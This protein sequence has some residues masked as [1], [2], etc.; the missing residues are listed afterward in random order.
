MSE[1]N[2]LYCFDNKFWKMALVSIYS[3]LKSKADGT[4]YNIYC[5][6]PSGTRWAARRRISKIIRKYK[7]NIIFRKIKAKENPYGTY[8]Y[9]RWSPVIFYR[10]FAHKIFPGAE[11]MLY[12]DSDVFVLQDL[13]S[14]FNTDLQKYPIAGVL[15]MAPVE[16]LQNS[17]GKHVREF[18]KKY[19][20]GK[21]YINSGVLLMDMKKMAQFHDI[22]AA[23]RIP[24]VYPD[25]DLLNV[26][27]DRNIKLL[28]LKYNFA[29]VEISIKFDRAEAK[30][31]KENPAIIHYYTAKPYL[32]ENAGEKAYIAFF[33]AIAELGITVKELINNEQ[34]YSSTKTGIPFARLCN[35]KL[36]FFGITVFIFYD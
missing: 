15:D 34:R 23:V 29:P 28:P 14:L 6:V 1:I 21:I 35:N 20:K 33:N 10:L 19:M 12:L 31:A 36:K 16:S 13:T 32:C 24:L 3:L 27:F 18:K 17:N 5:M 2:I 4:V 8:D 7:C 22:F 30:E 9:S 11:R 25:Q 26:V